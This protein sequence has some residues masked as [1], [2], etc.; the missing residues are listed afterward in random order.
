[1]PSI[2]LQETIMTLAPSTD[3]N[4]IAATPLERIRAVRDYA[5]QVFDDET[6]AATWLGRANRWVGGGLCAVGA[7]CQDPSGFREAM[8][9]LR[10]IERL[11]FDRRSGNLGG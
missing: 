2:A 9:E 4:A 5:H 7:A 8:A 1:M 3:W 11:A 6:H 10:R